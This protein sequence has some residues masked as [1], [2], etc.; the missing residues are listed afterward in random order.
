MTYL[1]WIR[2]NIYMCLLMIYEMSSIKNIMYTS[3]FVLIIYNFRN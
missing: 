1:Q 3:I 2:H